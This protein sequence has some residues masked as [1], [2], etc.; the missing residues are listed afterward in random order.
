MPNIDKYMLTPEELGKKPKL[1][2]AL[3]LQVVKVLKKKAEETASQTPE[4][5]KESLAK[6]LQEL[7]SLASVNT[8]LYH[9][10]MVGSMKTINGF[11][12]QVLQAIQPLIEKA[13]GDR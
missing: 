7:S 2:Y 13:K 3:A 10:G 5:V 11:L 6:I 8:Q 4:E 12:L 9:Y 1:K